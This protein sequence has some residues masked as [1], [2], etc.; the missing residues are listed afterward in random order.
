MPAMAQHDP[1]PHEMR[2]QLGDHLEALRRRVILALMGVLA[3]STVMLVFGRQLIAWLCQPLIHAQ[4]TAGVSTQT[5]AMSPIAGF[6]AYLKVSLIAGVVVALPWAV[7]QLWR[8]FE[9]A[10]YPQEQRAVKLLAPFSGVMSALG[11]AFMYYLMLPVCLWFLIAFTASFP[12][13]GDHEPS[14][15]FQAWQTSTP[16]T[17]APSPTP[18]APGHGRLSV[19]VLTQDPAAPTDGQVWFNRPQRQ[20]KLY[21]DGQLQR[22]AL[23]TAS[24]VSPLIE[25]G[26]YLNF[27]IVLTVGIVVAFQLPVIMLIVGWWGLADPAV[28]ARYRKHCVLACFGI[29]ML[30]TPADVLS[31]ILL[32]L[33]LWALF[34][35]GLLLMRRAYRHH[36]GAA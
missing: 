2:M 19:P 12:A 14:L 20:L 7:Y 36:R 8:F 1:P 5:Y 24:L 9:S 21:A 26:Q 34:E 6:G 30:L 32:G 35:F 4:R 15:I 18:A 10:L 27:V 22:V 11:V 16:P 25:I 31:M 17:T 29:G 3:T 28:L 33:P 23:T 13:V